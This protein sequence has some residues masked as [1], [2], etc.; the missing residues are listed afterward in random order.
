MTVLH[1]FDSGGRAVILRT[2]TADDVARIVALLAA[3]PLRAG[4]GGAS[5][6]EELAPYLRAFEQ[7][8]DDPAHLL[9]VADRDGEIVGTM[10]ISF[11]PGIA[12]R[13]ALRTQLEAGAGCADERSKG[14]GSAMVTWAVDEARRRGCALVQLTSHTS[15]TDAHRFYDRLGFHRP[16]RRVRAP[17]LRLRTSAAAAAGAPR[18]TARG[19]SAGRRPVRRWT[20]RRATC[21]SR[22]SGSGSRR[23][24][25]RR[26]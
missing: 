11:L 12:R 13:G 21:T 15:R 14:I 6:D 5:N 25:V 10:Q 24:A 4:T 16:A 22:R 17:A 18:R 26:R 7:I 3:D 9:V 8:D 19:W 20:P 23:A 2:A 1:E